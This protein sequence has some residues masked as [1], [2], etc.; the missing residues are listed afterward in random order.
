MWSTRALQGGLAHG[1]LGRGGPQVSSP[2]VL[3]AEALEL[4]VTEGLSPVGLPEAHRATQVDRR[5]GVFS[6]DFLDL[7]SRVASENLHTGGGGL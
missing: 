7:L 1:A 3:E 4:L 2:G 5:V 6:W